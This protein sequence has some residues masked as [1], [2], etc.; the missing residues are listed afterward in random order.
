MK[1]KLK[2][3]SSLSLS[4]V[5]LFSSFGIASAQIIGVVAEDLTDA[6]RYEYNMIELNSSYG[7]WQMDENSED[8]KLYNHFID[9]KKAVAFRDDVRGYVSV[10][11]VNEAYAEAQISGETFDANTYT[12]TQAQQ[13]PADI[14]NDLKTVTVGEN[15][16]IDEMNAS[17]EQFSIKILSSVVPGNKLV[18]V[19]FADNQNPAD[20]DVYIGDVQLEYDE[21]NQRFKGDVL[22]SLANLNNVRRE[23]KKEE[24]NY[25]INILSSTVPGEKQVYVT[26]FEGVDGSKYEVFVNNVGLEYN[27]DKNRFQGS[28]E[29]Q[30]ASDE[31]VKV[32]LK[33]ANVEEEL[34][35]VNIY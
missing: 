33:E 10:D 14:T 8:A 34:E 4:A 27:S 16:Q 26:F 1:R 17:N 31:Y 7:E 2:I 22:E 21:A 23:E 5:L 29:E 9:N 32:T 25:E 18:Y 35:V 3:L 30:Y 20:Y 12:E 15:G 28:V 24:V 6:T 11:D 19:Y 13:S